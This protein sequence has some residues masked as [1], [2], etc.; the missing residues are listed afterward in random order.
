MR[1]YEILFFTWLTHYTIDAVRSHW[2][3]RYNH[4]VGV[5]APLPKVV[6]TLTS[7]PRLHIKFTMKTLHGALWDV[8][9]AGPNINRGQYLDKLIELIDLW[10]IMK[11]LI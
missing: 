11:I 1:P 9:T 4:Q 2:S 6:T 10:T 5:D 8:N 7:I 3:F